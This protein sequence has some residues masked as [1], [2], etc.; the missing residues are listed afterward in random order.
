MTEPFELSDSEVELMSLTL[1]RVP[2][3]ASQREEE[4]LRNLIKRVRTFA[5]KQIAERKRKRLL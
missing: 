4:T 3:R 1:P 5:T 2:L